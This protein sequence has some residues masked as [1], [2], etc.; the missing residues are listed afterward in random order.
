ML[1]ILQTREISSFAEAVN[2]NELGVGSNLARPADEPRR[3]RR[4]AIGEHLEAGQVVLLE[5]SE[6]GEQVNHRR[7]KDCVIDPLVLDSLAKRL[8]VE[9]WQ[10]NLASAE[11]R[12]GEQRRKIG[13]ME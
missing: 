5:I 13:D 9:A 4:S 3:H 11:R 6:L 12:R 2:L 10:R 1:V 8:R 7:Y